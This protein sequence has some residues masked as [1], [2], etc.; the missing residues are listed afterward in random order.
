LL[1]ELSDK[2]RP[3]PT[4]KMQ[5]MLEF[6]SDLSIAVYINNCEDRSVGEM[7]SEL[8]RRTLKDRLRLHLI[9]RPVLDRALVAVVSRAFAGRM[10]ETALL[11]DSTE[12]PKLFDLAQGDAARVKRVVPFLDPATDPATVFEDLLELFA[13]DVPLL[14]ALAAMTINI[15]AHVDLEKTATLANRLFDTASGSSRL[16]I[17]LGFTTRLPEAGP[18]WTAVV[19][20]LTKRLLDEESALLESGRPGGLSDL[21]LIVLPLFEAYARAGSK[22]PLLTR[23]LSE[24]AHE[25]PGRT[26]RIVCAL[27]STGLRFPQQVL[28]LIAPLVTV[29]DV[30]GLEDALV[31]CLAPLRVVHPQL[32]DNALANWTAPWLRERVIA[33][34]DVQLVWREIW[35]LGLYKNAVHQALHYPRMRKNLLQ[36]GILSLVTAK[37]PKDFL[38]SFALVPL[39]M[40]READYELVGWTLP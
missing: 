7:T 10:L 33:A 30:P 24:G 20:G 1:F 15:H 11:A 39:R 5:A 35:W 40:L 34:D 27:S 8:W 22:M 31:T 2:A 37:K 38:G 26:T 13:S 32:V 23:L 36:G 16:W 29:R 28:D 17:V 6:M 19:E 14:K 21:D 9:N 12:V 3:A 25:H 4:K 18:G